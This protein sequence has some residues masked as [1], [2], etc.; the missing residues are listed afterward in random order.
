MTESAS[1]LDVNQTACERLGYGR[2]E[3]LRMKTTDLD[4]PEYDQQFN[5]RM[6]HQIRHGRLLNIE[7]L[8]VTR[9]KRPILFW[10]TR[11]SSPIK[12]RLPSSPSP[13]TL[14]NVSVSKKKSAARNKRLR[15]MID[16]AP[17][18]IYAKDPQIRFTC[19]ANKAT[20]EVL[21]MK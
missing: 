13:V 16:N 4:A 21:G 2:D 12:D 18:Q 5:E 17:A 6:E 3:L 20:L 15:T 9:D 7:G 10:S 11:Q 1:I 14:P 8:H 19:V